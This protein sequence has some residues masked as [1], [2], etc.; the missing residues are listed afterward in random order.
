MIPTVLRLISLTEGAVNVKLALI[1][2]LQLSAGDQRDSGSR[3]RGDGETEGIDGDP[4]QGDF[5]FDSNNADVED[6]VD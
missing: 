4:D 6:N 5:D 2:V 3:E 1:Q